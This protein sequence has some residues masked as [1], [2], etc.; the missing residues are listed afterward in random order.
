MEELSSTLLAALKKPSTSVDQKI[1]LFNT[2][3]SGIKHNRV[4]DNCQAPILECVRIAI[5]T[6]A[7][8]SLVSIGFSTLSHLIKR[9]VLQ[10]QTAVVTSQLPKLFP[11][12]LDRLYDTRDSHRNAAS[13]I[14]KDLWPLAHTDVETLIRENALKGKNTGAKETAMQWVVMVSCAV[15][16]L[17]SNTGV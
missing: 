7:S 8:A 14:L 6:S 4:P 3:K 1:Q 5:S 13:L 15:A 10:N 11:I 17:G 2:L 9:L 12:L 16:S